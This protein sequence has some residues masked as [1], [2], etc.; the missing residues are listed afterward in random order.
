[1][2]RYT[3]DELRAM[4]LEALAARERFDVRWTVLL[5][6]LSVRMHMDPRD[7]EHEIEKLAATSMEQRYA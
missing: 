4:A 5:T 3:T 7:V 1:M 6:V 2:S